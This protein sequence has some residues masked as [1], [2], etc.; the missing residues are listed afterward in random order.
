VFQKPVKKLPF[1]SVFNFLAFRQKQTAHQTH[2]GMRWEKQGLA[3]VSPEKGEKIILTPG[4]IIIS[5]RNGK[6]YITIA[7]PIHTVWCTKTRSE[8]FG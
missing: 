7:V 2:G 5:D 4:Y 3:D 1:I 8:F 6:L